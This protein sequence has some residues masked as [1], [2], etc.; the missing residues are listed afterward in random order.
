M[1][2]VD[3]GQQVAVPLAE[4]GLVAALKDVPPAVV[5]VIKPPRIYGQ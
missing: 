3:Q 1:D 2:V 4:N 5:A